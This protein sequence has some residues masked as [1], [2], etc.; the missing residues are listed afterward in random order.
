M[1]LY[2]YIFCKVLIQ[3][4]SENAAVLNYKTLYFCFVEITGL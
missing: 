2:V 1:I 4:I 3:Q